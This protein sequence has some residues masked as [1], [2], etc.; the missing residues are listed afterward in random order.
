[1]PTEK[2]TTPRQFRLDAETLERLDRI[3][4]HIGATVNGK[5]NRAAAIRFA[6]KEAAKKI[7]KNIS[8]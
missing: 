7:P 8:S 4:S 2:E 6:A 1:M 5:P 3:A